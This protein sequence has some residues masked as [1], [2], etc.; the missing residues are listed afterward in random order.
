MVKFP[1]VLIGMNSLPD[2]YSHL[3]A[4]VDIVGDRYNLGSEKSIEL[5]YKSRKEFLDAFPSKKGKNAPPFPAEYLLRKHF[6]VPKQQK[7]RFD[8][9]HEGERDALIAVLTER[10]KNIK[11]SQE[12][13]NSTL[14]YTALQNLYI[15]LQKLLQKLRD[16]PNRGASDA[17]GV[18]GATVT[19]AMTA[20]KSQ[21][22]LTP[23]PEDQVLQIILEMTWYL[24]HPEDAS[25]K[26]QGQWKEMLDTLA[27]TRIGDIVARIRTAQKTPHAS[28]I[29]PLNY[30]KKMNIGT[31]ATQPTMKNALDEAVKMAATVDDTVSKED[32]EKRLKTL[33]LVLQTKKYLNNTYQFDPSRLDVIDTD[34]VPSLQTTLPMNPMSNKE[35]QKLNRSL[36]TAM[37]PFSDHFRE[38]FD[39]VYGFVES[40]VLSYLGSK[41]TN[42]G[43]GANT[44]SNILPALLQLQ[45]VSQKI[46]YQAGI[47]ELV[48][49]DPD[50]LDFMRHLL[51][52]TK[53][54][55]KKLETNS[56]A[57]DNFTVQLASLPQVRLADAVPLS[58][59]GS[60]DSSPFY[61]Q[62]F[63]EGV[64]L[65]MPSLENYETTRQFP[66]S[67]H[68]HVKNL[69]H[70][71]SLYATVSLT[72]KDRIPLEFHKIDMKEVDTKKDTIK[73]NKQ[74]A[75]DAQEEQ[76]FKNKQLEDL[77][78]L[79]PA[80]RCTLTE[81]A[82]CIWVVFQDR[83]S[84]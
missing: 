2:E 48:N 72:Q 30:F 44:D 57:K 8:F 7:R 67:I 35:N 10:A 29:R 36:A 82:L 3:P 75:K 32:M 33:L 59:F 42:G 55:I 79:D 50:L 5:G 13:A 61:V 27:T 78:D 16:I 28:V 21:P 69:I 39:P 80:V 12:F 47:Y 62:Y 24:L 25:P 43:K 19:D 65:T 81:I 26:L 41:K 71:T 18:T 60:S 83:M 58:L 14:K 9:T 45:Y 70:P 31:F 15:E 54:E 23:I 22:V 53:A 49:V 84:K 34:V 17:N 40:S 20:K 76:F 37:A 1:I 74:K 11:S 68:E 63:M 66:A 64:N 73:I 6:G 51:Q 56:K 38:M 52:D 46:E 4:M 77:V